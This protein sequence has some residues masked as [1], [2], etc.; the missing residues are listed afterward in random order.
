MPNESSRTEIDIAKNDACSDPPGRHSPT[1]SGSLRSNIISETSTLE[2]DQVPFETFRSQAEDL[3]HK[4]WCPTPK[5]SATEVVSAAPYR[6]VLSILRATRL[7]K[8]SSSAAPIPASEKKFVIERL[9]GG[10][11]NRIIGITGIDPEP[12]QCILRIGRGPGS[13]PDREAAMLRFV[14]QYTNIPV[15]EVA[16][17]D[18]TDDNPIQSPYVMQSRIPGHNLQHDGPS[19]YPSLT[20]EQKCVVAEKIGKILRDLQS[21]QHFY[22]GLIEASSNDDHNQS[23]SIRHLE[24][25]SIGG[26]EAESDLNTKIPIFQSRPFEKHSER[27][28]DELDAQAR[29]EQSTFYFLAIQFG[30]WK[31]LELRKDPLTITMNHYDR[32]LTMAEQMNELNLLGDDINCLC[33]LDLN[34]APRNIMAQI[35]ADSSLQVTGILDWDSAIF[36]PRFVGCVPPMW[37]WAWSDEGEEDE[38]EANEVPASIEQQDLKQIFEKAVGDDFLQY[39]YRREYRLARKLFQFALDG[40]G[41][42]GAHQEMEELLEEW[43]AIYEIYTRPESQIDGECEISTESIA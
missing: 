16:F 6:H 29:F 36:A 8:T 32:L 26:V 31:A 30:R 33:H 3:C 22:P 9:R 35:Q 38:C 41:H 23:F 39:S 27:E 13:R 12:L 2:Y 40:M 5:S 14:R 21:I 1:Y 10:G 28:S 37:L 15:P 42:C 7:S 18:L 20:H 25:V 4:L 17:L 11:F 24:L 19:Y 34:N 43:A